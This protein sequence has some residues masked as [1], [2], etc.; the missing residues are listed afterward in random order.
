MLFLSGCSA[1]DKEEL[2]NLA[3]PNPASKEAHHIYDLWQGAWL[4]AILTGILVWG[5]M[6]YVAVKYRRRSESEIPVQTRYNLPIEIF[7]TVAPVMMVIVFFFF[8]VRAQDD[9][10][11]APKD[12]Q[13]AN[14]QA[15]L[16]ITVV[17]QQWSWTFNYAKGGTTVKETV[18]DAGTPAKIPTLYL[19]KDKSVSFDL[20][21]PDVIHSFWPTNF[22]FKMDVVPGRAKENHFT[23]TPTESGEFVGR[24]A[25]LCGVYHSR[26][27]FNVKV[28][29]QAE[30]DKHLESLQA[31]GNTGM[32]APGPYEREVKG[33][34]RE[35][36]YD[37]EGE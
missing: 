23:L 24:C 16:N 11:H 21:S 5:L 17:G 13:E 7:Y 22:L 32:N 25:E 8:T 36:P 20:Y 31:A 6:F 29:S 37:G 34:E 19:V 3:M 18:W 33:L 4:A 15:D 12:L 10:L 30:F 35:Q 14:A 1:K 28:V 27:L 2:K 9:V 26:M